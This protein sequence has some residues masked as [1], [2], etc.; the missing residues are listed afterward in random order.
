MAHDERDVNLRQAAAGDEAFLRR[1]LWLAVHWRASDAPP[2]VPV[3]SPEVARYTDGFG[4]HGDHGWVA[5]CHGT[6]IGA[7]WSR[8]LTATTAG[9]GYVA[10]DIPELSVAVLPEHRGV[11]VGG[12]LIERLL[13]QLAADFDAISLSVEAANPAR[14]LYERH[15]FAT[16]REQGGALTMVKPLSE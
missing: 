11:G 6:P 13:S 5:T 4:R 14:V 8:L 2:P 3:V 16:F 9:Y 12:K 1:M 15:G 10:D 7:A